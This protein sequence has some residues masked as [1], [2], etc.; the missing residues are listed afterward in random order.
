MRLPIFVL[1]PWMTLLLSEARRAT[2]VVLLIIGLKEVVVV[3]VLILDRW[4]L[5]WKCRNEETNGRTGFV[6]KRRHA[7]VSI[8]EMFA[9]HIGDNNNPFRTEDD[10]QQ[11]QKQISQLS[12]E[13]Y[14][15]CSISGMRACPQVSRTVWVV[16]VTGP[17]WAT[18]TT[19]ASDCNLFFF[20]CIE[21]INQSTKQS[22]HTIP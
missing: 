8:V 9:K 19:A 1:Y 11:K 15:C 10:H 21:L 20:L 2:P 5:Y 3:D 17:T 4:E 6:I 7:A 13:L 18:P 16:S 12:D 22:P 14:P